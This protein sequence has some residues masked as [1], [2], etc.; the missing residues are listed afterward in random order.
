MKLPLNKSFADF[1]N[2]VP[3]DPQ[4]V[5]PILLEP[6]LLIRNPMV[7]GTMIGE[8]KITFYYL[9]NSGSSVGVSFPE[10]RRLQCFLMIAI[11]SSLP[12]SE[13]EM[14]PGSWQAASVHFMTFL[15][16]GDPNFQK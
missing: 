2:D 6:L 13:D 9:R 12:E 5:F 15:V 14:F 4:V 7:Q 8:R 10:R 11:K 1:E 3:F 16:V